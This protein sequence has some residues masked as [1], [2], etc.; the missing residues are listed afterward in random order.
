MIS[1]AKKPLLLTQ[2]ESTAN[3]TI[4][5]WVPLVKKLTRRIPVIDLDFDEQVALGMVEVWKCHNNYD[6]KRGASFMTHVHNRLVFRFRSERTLSVEVFKRRKQ[7]Q[8]KKFSEY[9]NNSP[10]RHREFEPFFVQDYKAEDLRLV[11]LKEVLESMPAQYQFIVAKTVE[12]YKQRQICLMMGVTKQC[13]SLILHKVRKH[14]N[15]NG[16]H[17]CSKKRHSPISPKDTLIVPCPTC[18]VD[19]GQKCSKGKRTHIA[20]MHEV[21]LVRKEIEIAQCA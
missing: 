19:V 3:E 16:Y 9:E 11:S 2:P 8:S 7:F 10:K 5:K 12:G 18:G 4:K 20:R 13:V 14:L 17:Q 1:E 6:P 15:E 21:R